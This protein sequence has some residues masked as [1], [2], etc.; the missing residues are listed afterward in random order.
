MTE[1]EESSLVSF[2]FEGEEG[3]ISILVNNSANMK[4]NIS[5]IKKNVYIFVILVPNKLP[6]PLLE[7]CDN[8]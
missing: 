3:L 2:H 8:R 1:D 5:S 4:Q 6:R 7:T